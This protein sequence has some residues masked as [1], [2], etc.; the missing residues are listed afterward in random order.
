MMLVWLYLLIFVKPF[1]VLHV[2]AI[3]LTAHFASSSF[4]ADKF[5]INNF[6][7]DI[8]VLGLIAICIGHLFSIL[9]AKKKIY[10]NKNDFNV[11]TPRLTFVLS[12]FLFMITYHYVVGGIP[13]LSSD[14]LFSRFES[15]SSGMFGIPGRFNL[16]GN[17]FLFFLCYSCFLLGGPQYKK[18][19]IFSMLILL[20]SLLFKGSK[21]TLIHFLVAMLIYKNVSLNKFNLR[22]RGLKL[23]SFLPPLILIIASFSY[24]SFVHIEQGARYSNL[25]DLV[26]TR[27]LEISGKGYFTA[28][29]LYVENE[30]YGLGANSINDVFAFFDRLFGQGDIYF[31]T[32]E[33]VSALTNGLSLGIHYLVPMEINIFGYVYMEGGIM[34]V[35][36]TGILL[37]LIVGKTSQR[38]L[39]C[40]S[41]KTM[42]TLMFFQFYLFLIIIKGNLIFLTISMG[43]SYIIFRLI[44]FLGFFWSK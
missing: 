17:F 11:S 1:G 20:A 30:G 5:G 6:A 12:F 2:G 3:Y 14:I 8:I 28:V 31:Y 37:G 35:L 27:V 38:I 43:I 22:E 34:A 39:N 18:L 13:L 23:A 4:N 42:T 41:I 24:I 33:K 26:F 21:G 40:Y 29:T 7:G 15:T 32:S 44:C 16:F 10:L 9:T 19:F 25:I 36:F